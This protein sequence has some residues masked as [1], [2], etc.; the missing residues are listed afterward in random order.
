MGIVSRL[1]PVHDP[2]YQPDL[3]DRL[4]GGAR[5][6]YPKLIDSRLAYAPCGLGFGVGDA[7]EKI[8]VLRTPGD[9]TTETSYTYSH[10]SY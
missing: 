9:T 7:T 2:V 3:P 5:V 4:R 8:D 6:V 1:A 10:E